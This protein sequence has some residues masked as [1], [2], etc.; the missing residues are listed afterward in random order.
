MI[1]EA[2]RLFRKVCGKSIRSARI[3]LAT[4]KIS[5]AERWLGP[6]AWTSLA[7]IETPLPKWLCFLYA[8]PNKVTQKLLD[9]IAEH[10]ELPKY[11][12]MPPQHASAPVLKRMKRGASGDIF[13]KL[14]ER[15]RRTIPGVAIRTSFHRRVPGRDRRRLRDPL[16][17]CVPPAQIDRPGVFSLF[18]MKTPAR[19]LPWTV[20]SMA[21]RF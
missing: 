15:I 16:P 20:K 18:L 7:Q 9:T 8:Y 3:R 19:A 21:A 5:W 12:D 17:V 6:V 2:T 14:I 10:A 11:I 13:L 4:G 1:S